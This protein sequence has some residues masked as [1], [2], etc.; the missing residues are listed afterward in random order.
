LNDS[1][2]LSQWSGPIVPPDP[3]ELADRYAVS[4]LVKVY[5]LGIDMRDYNLARSVFADDAFAEGT[6]GA[7]KVDEY[8]PKVYE[9][10][11]PYASTQHNITNQYVAL[12][13][14]RATLLSYAVAYHFEDKNSERRNLILGV[15]Y[16]D[17]CLRTPRGWLIKKRKVKLQWVDGP[18]PR[19]P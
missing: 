1:N 9:G 14:D 16:R 19:S 10:V 3:G 12:D 5:A 2:D 17:Q 8:L 6:L 7:A 11:L 4:Q 15:Q 13:G 18:L